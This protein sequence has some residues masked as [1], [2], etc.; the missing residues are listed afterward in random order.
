MPALT[1][2]LI[3]SVLIL[4]FYYILFYLL[5]FIPCSLVNF[6]HMNFIG[7][8]A[9]ILKSALISCFFDTHYESKYNESDSKIK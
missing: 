8:F 6:L 2:M 5:Y 7:N 3:S 1:V 9:A 4:I